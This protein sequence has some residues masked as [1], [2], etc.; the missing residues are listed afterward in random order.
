MNLD[1]LIDRRNLEL[2]TTLKSKFEIE[3]IKE[4]RDTHSVFTKKDKA[5]IR[6]P[7]RP[8]IDSFTHELLHIFMKLKDIYVGGTITLHVKEDPI[9]SKFMSDNLTEHIGNCLE[10]IKM[11][12]EFLKMGFKREEFIF[13]YHVNKLTEKELDSIKRHFRR[14]PLFQKEQF[15]SKAIDLYIGKYFAVKAC[16]NKS[17]PYD[18]GQEEL[19]ELDNELYSILDRFMTGWEKFDYNDSDIITGGYND[20]VLDLATGLSDWGRDKRIV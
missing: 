13:D 8:S 6:V 14:K 7:F 11:L 20:I 16:P 18:K 4:N 2:W 9:L 12:P 10:H 3:I 17:F 5:T 19:R 15:Y 1:G